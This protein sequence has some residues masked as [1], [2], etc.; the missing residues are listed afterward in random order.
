[1][2]YELMV[3]ANEAA[4]SLVSFLGMEALLATLV[5]LP[6]LLLSRLLRG[7]SPMLV[8]ALWALVLIRLVLPLDLKSPIGIGSLAAPADLIHAVEAIGADF[9][10]VLADAA[11]SAGDARGIPSGGSAAAG[12]NDVAVW[13]IALGLAW[14]AGVLTIGSRLVGRRRAHRALVRDASAV[15]DAHC[16][17]LSERWRR[18]LRIRRRVRL[19]S[20]DE[21]LAPFTCGSLN[22]VIYL[23]AALLRREEA[24]VLESVLAHE[25]AHVKRWDDLMLMAQ[26]AIAALYFFHP[27][28]WLSVRR[29]REAVERGCDELVLSRGRLAPKTYGR[30]I[31]AVLRLKLS[32]HPALA[33]ALDS[34]TRRIRMRLQ[35]IMRKRSRTGWRARRALALPAALGLGLLLLPLAGR[36]VVQSEIGAAVPGLGQDSLVWV[37]PMPGAR[38]TSWFGPALNPFTG[39]GAQHRGIDLAGAAGSPVLAAAA[40]VVEE[41]TVEYSGGSQNGTVVIL[42]HGAGIKSFYSHLDEL[43]VGVG[44]SV[45]AGALIAI[46]GSTGKVTG[47]HLHLEIW[48][49]GE[50]RDPAL[51]IRELS[52]V[53]R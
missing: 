35:A 11:A 12:T 15:S 27:L 8:Q 45:P 3:L 44:E 22:P 34:N 18:E 47:A 9:G 42:D 33:P 51:Y 37:D 1:M 14:L 43:R 7:A 25:L 13:P 10:A 16:L 29:V 49:A 26:L 32:G 28:A 5:F 2:A 38:I 52:A 41:A 53:Q 20:S 36:P 50:P 46:Q 23:P 19:V 24:D 17:E 30:S 40:G 31:I 48:V 21:S 4:R 39:Q 6:V